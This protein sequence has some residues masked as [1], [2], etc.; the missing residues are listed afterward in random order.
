M[1]NLPAGFPF[2]TRRNETA[3]QLNPKSR[4]RSQ[5]ACPSARP[6]AC[7][8]CP[9][10]CPRACRCPK[11]PI[12]RL[13]LAPR[14]LLF[15]CPRFSSRGDWQWP[16]TVGEN[17]S[18]PTFVF[19]PSRFFSVQNLLPSVETISALR[20]RYSGGAPVD[21]RTWYT[22]YVVHPADVGALDQ[23]IQSLRHH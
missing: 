21:C 12:A 6:R 1:I 7:R 4:S 22:L 17:F 10:A 8:P 15:F 18:R 19:R 16:T 11:E 13:V 20:R 3:T 14:T 9:R 2:P 5:R 23:R